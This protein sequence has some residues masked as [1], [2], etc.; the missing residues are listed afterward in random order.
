MSIPRELEEQILRFHFVEKWKVGTIAAQVGVH[1]STVRRVLHDEGVVSRVCENASMV[2]EYLPFIEETL[3]EFPTLPASRLFEMVKSRGY[4]GGPDHFRRI[5]SQVRPRKSAEAF[6]RLRTLIGEEGQ[7]DWGHFGHLQVG[8][9]RRP[10]SAF[11]LILSH[12]RMPFVRFSLDQR[13]GS[14]LTG[15]VEAFDFFGGVPRRVLYDNLK[16]VVLARRGDAIEF[17]TTALELAA[18]YRFEARPVAIRRGNEKGRVERLIRTLRT[19]FW[20]ARTFDD[21][22]DLNRQALRWCRETAGE[23]PCAEDKSRKVNDFFAQE[24]LHLL[25]LPDDAFPAEDVV[26]VSVGKQPYVRF[27]KNDYSVPPD[28]V[29]RQLTVRAST[30]KVRVLDGDTVVA[31]HKRTFSKQ[32]QVEDPKHISAL[33]ELKREAREGRGIDFLHNVAPSSAAFLKGAAER[34]HNL[35]SSVAALV[36]LA[37]NWPQEEL[38]A[39]IAEALY[40]DTL[41]TSAVRQVLQARRQ[42]A[43]L[44]PPLSVTLPDDERIRNVHVVP[45]EL[46]SYDLDEQGGCND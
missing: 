2:D 46:A 22:E 3:A 32:E 12:S 17:N 45:H 18:H 7:M 10:L 20:P 4:P 25:P 41:H 24:R 43:E 26:T 29:R 38:E 40:K 35:G 36:K 5:I 13:M 44:P 21:V 16:S 8:R 39:A 34:G 23:R 1:H 33:W 19:S 27:D 31:Q 6:H 28:R 15:H 9:A 42:K 30:S 11:A 37:G 14:F